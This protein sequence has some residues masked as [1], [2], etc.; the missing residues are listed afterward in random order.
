[1]NAAP[2]ANVNTDLDLA[3]MSVEEMYRAGRAAL[4]APVTVA[5][6]LGNIGRNVLR[7]D[8]IGN[9]D[10]GLI[11]NTRFGETRNLQFRVEMYNATNTR[12]FGIPQG[13]ITPT[14]FLNQWATDGG[15]RRVVLAL[16]YSF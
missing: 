2:R 14:D 15:N 16:R 12:N 7:T 3:S 1:M 9:L 13:A 10:L 4:F 8:G 6:P 11:K 5:S